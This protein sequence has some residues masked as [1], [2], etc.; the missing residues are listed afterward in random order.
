MSDSHLGT[1]SAGLNDSSAKVDEKNVVLERQF[2][3]DFGMQSYSHD[4]LA[5]TK[6]IV[7]RKAE[8]MANEYNTWWL[9]SAFVFSAFFCSF[10]YSLDSIIR[11]IY[12][13]YALND[14]ETQALVSTVD[15]VSSVISAV[16]QIFFA[17]LS[18][19]F[20]RLSLFV[21][22][23]VLYVVGTVIQSQAYD[24]KRY[25]AGSIFY[26]I[27]LVGVLFQV[28][29]ILSD[30]SSLRWR[31]FYNFVP[32]WPALIT[33]WI[34]GNVISVANPL[35]H[36]SWGIAMW[37]FIFPASCVPLIGCMLHMR[38]KVRNNPEWKKLQEEKTFFQSHG[39][40]KF[41]VQLFWA[42]DVIGVLLLT[43][44]T[45]CIL[46]PLTI[47]GGVTT[48]WRSAKVIAPF[49]LG[50]VLVPVFIYWESK[51]AAKPL[52]PFKLL[53]DRGIWAPLSIY[54]LIAFVYEMAAGYLYN[55]L[56]VASNET[57]L[58]ATRI[59]SLYSFS[60]AICS[61][62]VG[63]AVARSSRMKTYTI[64]G[65]SLYFVTMALFYHYRGGDNSGKG[66]I[67]AM[68]VWGITSCLYDYPISVIIQTVTSH[69]LLATVAA[70]NQAVFGIGGA[71]GAA[72]SGA[73]WTQILY[74]RLL[75]ALGDADIAEAAY[76][77]PLSFITEYEWGTPVRTATVEAYR[78]VQKYEVLVGLVFVAPMF[79]LTFFLRD[80]LLTNDYGQKLKEGEYIKENDDPISIWLAKRFSA[81]R[82]N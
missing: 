30:C 22:S 71:V 28:A 63:I 16:G 75:K 77:S 14:Y 61:P 3:D 6:S 4:K 47:A 51:L 54:F 49:V 15:V 74:P 73:I 8:L 46:V 12:M 2:S 81:L 50:F 23:I 17:S 13:S 10:A 45:G 41:I 70:L 58:S 53:K 1:F 42:L 37:A 79:I 24:V 44:C 64:V 48:S 66:M 60:A 39:F 68:V 43:V 57:D 55:I 72:V 59:S 31:L 5:A 25:A 33:V 19:I 69:E 76:D 27:G 35:E 26:N 56:V 11:D 9:K 20:G 38:W 36:W 18:D 78:Y 29:I 21:V 32:A 40:V 52:A 80:P 62:L 67:G 34:S 65:C 82:K 7:I